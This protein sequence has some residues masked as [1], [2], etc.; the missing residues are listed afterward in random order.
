MGR[1]VFSIYMGHGNSK[2]AMSTG[3]LMWDTLKMAQNPLLSHVVVV[4][5]VSHVVVVVLLVWVVV[6]GLVARVALHQHARDADCVGG[7]ISR[8]DVFHLSQF[9]GI[10]IS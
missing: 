9:F 10:V 6:D 2:H 3:F 7:L 4:L 8:V 5:M 1:Q